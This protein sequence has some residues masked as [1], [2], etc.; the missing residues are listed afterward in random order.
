MG[1]RLTVTGMGPRS[2]LGVPVCD[3]S[4]QEGDGVGQDRG[5]SR[6]LPPGAS[7]AALPRLPQ[8]LGSRLSLGALGFLAVLFLILWDAFSFFRGVLFYSPSFI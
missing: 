6:P 4:V 8:T 1:T 5:P 3:R 7:L 2:G